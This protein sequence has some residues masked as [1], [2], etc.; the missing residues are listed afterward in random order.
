MMATHLKPGAES[1][2]YQNREIGVRG[3]ISRG[4]DTSEPQ[5]RPLQTQ[6]GN[7]F[8]LVSFLTNYEFLNI[9]RDQ[10]NGW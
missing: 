7:G 5:P 4:L 9:F 8:A 3:F 1:T 10:Q 6:V 2:E